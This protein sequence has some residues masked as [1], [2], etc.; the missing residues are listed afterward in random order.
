MSDSLA[1]LEGK[2]S[3]KTDPQ[4]RPHGVVKNKPPPGH[5]GNP[6][7]D[8]VQLP[9]PLEETR[10]QDNPTSVPLKKA[11]HGCQPPLIDKQATAVAEHQNPSAQASD[12][13]TD[14]VTQHGGRPSREQNFGSG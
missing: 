14:Q 9:Q 3:P 2:G 7:H 1:Q 10:P 8:P 6:R 4:S 5:L 12:G 13:I 11:F